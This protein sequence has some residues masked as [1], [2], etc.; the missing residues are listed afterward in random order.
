MPF[1]SIQNRFTID[2]AP[3]A[4]NPTGSAFYYQ[5]LQAL[6]LIYDGSPTAAAAVDAWLASHAS[7]IKVE[8]VAGAAQ[9]YPGQGIIQIDPAYF[10]SNYYISTNGNAVKDTFESGLAHELSH[11]VTGKRDNESLANLSGDNVL[12]ANT[13]FSELGFAPQSSYEAYDVGANL[14]IPGFQYTQ[15]NSISNA[16]IDRG[17]GVYSSLGLVTWHFDLTALGVTGSTLILGGYLNN[18]Y[19]GTTSRDWIYGQGGEDSLNGGDGDDFLYGGADDDTLI[20]GAGNDEIWG[21]DAGSDQGL[22][23]GMDTVDYSSNFNFQS[24]RINFDSTAST[25]QLTV[26]DGLGGVDSL[27][28]IEKIIGTTGYDLLKITGQ[29]TSGTHL[30]VNANGGQNPNPIGSIINGAP[31]TTA[32]NVSI[33]SSGNGYVQSVGGGKI[34]LTGFHTQVVGTAF[35]DTISDDS[36]GEKRINGGG[37]R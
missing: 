4:T 6:Q 26:E 1:S 37:W 28:S 24:I 23:D 15:G 31:S 3:S 32:F 29:I 36:L 14:L 11:A 19:V 35:D 21:G 30:T 27:H 13:W 5:A 34:D 2:G 16:L 25:P 8:F 20:G 7:N 12:T 10:L 22:Q 33:D 18:L 9:A 17:T